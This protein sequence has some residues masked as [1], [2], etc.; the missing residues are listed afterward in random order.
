MRLIELTC[1]DFRALND[2]TLTPQPGINI[3]RGGNAQGKTTL[4]EALL[5]AATSKSHRTTADRDLVRHGAAGFHVRANVQRADRT[6]QVEAAYAHGSKRFKVNGVAQTR[7]SDILGRVHLVLFSPE[8]LNLVKAGAGVRRRFLDM[9]LSQ[10]DSRYLHA[11]QQYRQALRQRNELLRMRAPDPAVL[12]PWD[13]QLVQHGGVVIE[14]RARYIA[15]LSPYAAEAYAGIAGDEPLSVHYRPNTPA[16]DLAATLESRR[17]KDLR[18]KQTTHGPHLDDMEL[19]IS[20]T[21]ARAFGSQGQQRSAVLA[22]KLAELELIRAHVGEYPILMLD[23]VLAELDA[24][25]ARRLFEVVGDAV[26]CLVTTT[27]REPRLGFGPGDC[28]NFILEGGTLEPVRP[29]ED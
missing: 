9:E 15:E 21:D 19:H 20:G 23:E 8:D 27:E 1:R 6:V 10:I 26:Q 22:L 25:R 12:A 2:I 7:V 11:L 14:S 4:L 16:D 18:R 3:I 28:A 24:G 17:E 13:A 29:G 5:Y